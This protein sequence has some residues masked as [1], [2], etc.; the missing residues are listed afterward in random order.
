M[1]LAEIVQPYTMASPERVELLIDLADHVIV[2][3][4]LGDMVE[5]GVCNGGTAAILAHFASQ[6]GK[7]TWLFDSFEGM[8]PVTEEDGP[9]TDGNTAKSC[10]GKC[11]GN[12][13]KVREVIALAG[14]DLDKVTIVRGLFKKTFLTVFVPRIAMLIL[15]SDWYESEK[16]C[17]RKFYSSVSKGGFVYFDDFYYWPGCRRAAEEFF[18]EMGLRP[19]LNQVGHSMWMRVG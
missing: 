17:L 1:N 10:V 16:L 4:V 12:I 13:D 6:A 14:G 11:V 15:D 7:T 8:P 9:G 2:K 18:R 5:C 19:E 3:G